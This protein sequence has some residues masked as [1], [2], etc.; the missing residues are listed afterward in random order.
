MLDFALQIV[1]SLLMAMSVVFIVIEVRSRFDKSFLI[2]GITNLLLSAFCAI[3][4]WIQPDAQTIY[5]TRIQH[6]IAAFFPAFI[7]WY[8][9]VML[10]RSKYMLVRLMF[11]IGF[12][13][14][15]L[16]FT[17][18]ML[19]ASEKEIVSTP[20]YNFS[21]VPYMLCAMILLPIFLIRNLSRSAE[22]EKKVLVF[23]LIGIVFLSIGGVID[24]ITVIIGHRV[25]PDVASFSTI[26]LLLFGILVTYVFTDR[27]TSIIK[28]RETTF[29][30]LQT[31]YH[32]LEMTRP[33]SRLG[34]SIAMVN[35]EIKH[36]TF[37]LTLILKSMERTSLT[38]FL[39]DKIDECNTVVETIAK[40]NRDVLDQSGIWTIH[41][42][43]VDLHACIM[44]VIDSFSHK[45]EK[46]VKYEGP[47]SGL[48]VLGDKDKLQSVFENLFINSVEAGADN[49]KVRI[50]RT[51]TAITVEVEDNGKGCDQETI[52]SLF[53]TFFTTKKGQ[54]G[55][56]LGLSIVQ[57]I[58]ENLGGSI[59][60]YS[61]N[62]RNKDETGMV[63]T[64]LLPSAEAKGGKVN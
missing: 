63:F 52:N 14:T 29:G 40:F 21:F 15:L 33:L 25:A 12:C 38:P 9:L 23:H 61:K 60:A 55:T 22:K 8:L 47:D 46:P 7:T 1:C 44:E 64:I 58:I 56:G 57:T 50:S 39:R 4:I 59:K 41:K 42:E 32:E 62:L 5:W 31:A 2:F 30:K 35:H 53:T 51:G 34:R 36:K 10:L 48:T 16:F 18:F 45:W 11:F 3:D 43:H 17:N 24:L 49:I 37:N 27:L 20:L 13:F 19:L 54:R 28:D 6:V 26:G